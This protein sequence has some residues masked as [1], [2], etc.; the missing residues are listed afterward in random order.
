MA[1][2]GPRP[3]G[4]YD[5]LLVVTR[6]DGKDRYLEVLANPLLEATVDQTRPIAELVLSELDA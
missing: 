5:V 2:F 1:G 6:L 4:T 3:S